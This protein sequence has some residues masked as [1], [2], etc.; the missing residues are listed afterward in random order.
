MISDFTIGLICIMVFTM[1]TLLSHIIE[2][3]RPKIYAKRDFT[4]RNVGKI[5]RDLKKKGK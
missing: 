3:S 1:L 2:E 5:L 4:K